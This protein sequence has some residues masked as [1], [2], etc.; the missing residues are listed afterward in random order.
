MP[1]DDLQLIGLTIPFLNSVKYLGVI[2]GRMSWGLHIE[3]TVAKALGT[4]IRTYSIFTSKHL[5]VNIKL[6]V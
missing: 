6:I 2:F 5:S 3:T 1:E 4:Y